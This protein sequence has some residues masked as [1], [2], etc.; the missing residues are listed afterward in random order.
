MSLE[1]QIVTLTGANSIPSTNAKNGVSRP[2]FAQILGATL[3][4]LVPSENLGP[5]RLMACCDQP[6]TYTYIALIQ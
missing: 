3:L 4:A 5:P 6:S 2:T 1:L